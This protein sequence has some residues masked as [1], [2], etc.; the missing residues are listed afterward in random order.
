MLVPV[1]T[2]AQF[3]PKDISGNDIKQCSDGGYIIVRE[4]DED[5]SLIRTDKY[6]N[7]IWEKKF[8]YYVNS[9]QICSDGGFIVAGT[10]D[11]DVFLFKTDKNGLKLWEKKFGDANNDGAIDVQI[12]SD[13][14]FV[15]IGNQLIKTDK[16]GNIYEQMAFTTTIRG[17][18]EKT[19]SKSTG[20]R[21]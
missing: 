17:D 18:P 13:G 8:R 21:F 3:L 7:I 19:N 9:V 6:G 20:K 15:M 16:N 14:G 5:A 4:K 1:F 10:S 2:A 11:R 12:C